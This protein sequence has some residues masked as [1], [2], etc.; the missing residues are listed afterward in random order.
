MRRFDA[1]FFDFGGTLAYFKGDWDT[2]MRRA[3]G[4]LYK[5]LVE[6]G[7]YLSEHFVDEFF[8][9]LLDYYQ[10]RESDLVEHSTQYVLRQSL[11]ERGH[12]EISKEVVNTAISEFYLVTQAHWLVEEDAMEVLAELQNDGYRLGLISNAA[13]DADVQDQIDRANL[14]KFFD[15][16]LTSAGVGIR[17]PAAKIFHTAL[18]LMDVRPERAVMVGDTLRADILGA[19]NAGMFSIWIT[20]WADNPTNRAD[21]ITISPDAL[22]ADLSKM[23]T[24]VEKLEAEF[25]D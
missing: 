6:A 5:S 19:K 23:L 10:E 20:K 18:G 14:R 9:K 13:D 25:V 2:V 16:I 4:A 1:I 12:S 3:I 22:T 11:G 7:L 15:V 8:Q 21:A 17:K 24:L